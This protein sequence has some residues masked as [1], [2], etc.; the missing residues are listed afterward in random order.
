[1]IGVHKVGGNLKLDR[2]IN[3]GIL[4][5]I[6]FFFRFSPMCGEP[7]GGDTFGVAFCGGDIVD[8]YCSEVDCI[9]V[10]VG[11]RGNGVVA[12]L[13]FGKDL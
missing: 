2:R 13:H 8:Q 4:G 9:W 10:L 5:K 3:A 12:G 11:G 6:F 7:E 1:M